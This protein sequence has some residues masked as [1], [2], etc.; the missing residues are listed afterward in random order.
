MSKEYISLKE[1]AA[2][3]LEIKLK[4]LEWFIKD[5]IPWVKNGMGENEYSKTSGKKILDFFPASEYK[6]SKWST[7]KSENYVY[8]NC[9]FV[10]IQ[11]LDKFGSFSTSGRDT[12]K[13]Y[14]DMRNR[15][16]TAFKNLK[17]IAKEQQKERKDTI[18]K[19]NLK[20]MTLEARLDAIGASFVESREENARLKKK[21]KIKERE[22]TELKEL[23]DTQFEKI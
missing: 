11:I 9:E 15:A 2:I 10:K 5:G 6:F 8:S 1:K 22:I 4:V 21:L 18:S 20:I 14:S 7:E 23:L 17:K 3:N 13:K 19:Q 16:I 12:L